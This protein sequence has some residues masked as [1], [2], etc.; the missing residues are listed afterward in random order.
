MPAPE[1]NNKM[2]RKTEGLSL[3]I[4]G[5]FYATGGIR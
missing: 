5:S 1:N 2:A 3:D 4:Q